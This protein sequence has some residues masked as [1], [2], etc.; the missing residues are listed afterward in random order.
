MNLRHLRSFVAVAEE[1]SFTRAARRMG[2]AQPSLSQQIRALESDL[3]GPPI[4]RLPRGIR[5]PAGGTAL[6]PE[7]Q[8]AVRAAERALTAARTA[9]GLEAGELEVATLLS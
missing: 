3:G 2:I 1:G 6:L 4:E 9:M 8:A 5:L 7:A